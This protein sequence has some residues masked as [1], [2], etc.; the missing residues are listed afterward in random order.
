MTRAPSFKAGDRVV[1]LGQPLGSPD[2]KSWTIINRVKPGQIGTVAS[3][4]GHLPTRSGN[5]PEAYRV[6]WDGTGD[7]AVS[8]YFLQKIDE[9]Y[10]GNE[11]TT[12]DDCPF[13]PRE[14]VRTENPT[15]AEE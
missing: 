11:K 6:I 12:W 1:K 15:L 2:G 9:Y 13:K 10:D 5:V 4:V 14:L 7:Q 8:A 3:Y